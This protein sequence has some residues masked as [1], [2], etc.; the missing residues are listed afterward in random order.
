MTGRTAGLIGISVGGL[1]IAIAGL[2]DPFTQTL[3]VCGSIVF[4][5]GIIA[6][7]IAAKA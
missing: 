7:A 1:G 5:S 6:T 2:I 3:L 4:S